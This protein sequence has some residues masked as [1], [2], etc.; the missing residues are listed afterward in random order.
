MQ[1]A[2]LGGQL[3]LDFVNTVEYRHSAQQREFL[4]A[5]PHLLAWCRHAG[6]LSD[7]EFKHCWRAA[8]REPAMLDGLL[9]QALAL[10]ESLWRIFTG[11][12]QRQPPSQAQL[13]PLNE[14]LAA[15][16]THR[17]L[18]PDGAGLAW[19]WRAQAGP[20]AQ[21]L[22]TLC[23][24]AQQLLTSAELHKLRQCGG[25]GWFFLDTSRNH[26]R[27][28]C[29]MAACG[30]QMKSKRQYQRRVERAAVLPLATKPQGKAMGTASL[31]KRKAFSK[32]RAVSR[33][34][35]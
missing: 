9:K 35:S 24:A 17:H 2:L 14:A 18:V 30:G 3:S 8:Q 1:L 23:L 22:G 31:A 15:V 11:L 26:S 21:V 32:E 29:S 12:L 10:R 19:A 5:A 6:V 20:G 13:R 27:R 34:I 4:A 33:P 7:D 25:C 28:W 16:G